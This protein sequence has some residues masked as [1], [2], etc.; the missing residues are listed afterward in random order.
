MAEFIQK[1]GTSGGSYAKYFTGRLTVSEVSYSVE[2]NTSVVSWVLE[3]ISGSSGRF[4]GYSGNWS[5]NIDGQAYSGSGTYSS[6]SYNTAQTIASGT[7]TIQHNNDGSKRNMS[8]SAV[9]DFASGSYSPGDFNLSGTMDLT[10]IPRASKITAI[11]ANIES[12]TTININRAVSSFTHTIT[13]S[14]NGLSGTIANKTSDTSVGFQIPASFYEKIP[15]S[16]TGTVTLTCTTYNGDIVIGTSTTTFTV[17]AS[18]EKCKPDILAVLIDSNEVT[19]ALTGDNSKLIKY[20]STAKITP[21]ITAKNSARIKSITVNGYTVSGNYI[22]FENIQSETFTVIATDSRGY[23]N[24]LEVKPTIVQYIP[25][26]ATA[27][28]DRLSATSSEVKVKYNGNYYNGNFGNINNA[29]TVKWAYKEKD[30]TTWITGGTL[31]PIIENNTFSGEASLGTIF[32]YKKAY[33][34]ILYVSDKLSTASPVET[35]KKGNPYYDYGTDENGNNYFNVN[36]E[37]FKNSEKLIQKDIITYKATNNQLI[38]GNQWA[39]IQLNQ[40]VSQIGNKLTVSDDNGI[41]IGKNVS[42]IKINAAAWLASKGYRW[43]MVRKNDT[44]IIT[45]ILPEGEDNTGMW[46]TVTLPNVLVD[47]SENDIIYLYAFLSQDGQCSAG[48]YA[49]TSTY[50]TVEVVE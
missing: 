42:K 7:T 12:A 29:L 49:P 20:K 16:K 15:N 30:A 13:Y 33:D 25:L 40:I 3:L 41:K 4:S 6:M 19:T 23:S 34:F 17:T 48:N 35:I 10:N 5:V 22:A 46:G 44:G 24:A 14:F 31:T 38:T 11:D 47:V 27:K 39:K 45:A 36:G 37:Y 8:C 43:V 18:E 9:M 26:S 50:L 28:F 2:N 21:T 1:G 32:N